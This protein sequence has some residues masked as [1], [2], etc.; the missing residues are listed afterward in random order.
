MAWEYKIH[1]VRVAMGFSE[2]KKQIRIS[3]FG[4]STYPTNKESNN[5]SLLL[6]INIS[7]HE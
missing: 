4:D 2:K 1:A 7:L 3:T 6:L 5:F